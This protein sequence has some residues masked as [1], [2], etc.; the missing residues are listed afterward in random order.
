MD[1]MSLLLL[2][3]LAALG[4]F[5]FDSLHALEVARNAGK[6][7][8]SNAHVQFLDDTVA[9]VSL[10]LVRDQAGRRVLRRTYRF[11][12][13]ETG[14]SRREGHLVLLGSRV[15]SVMMEP[16]RMLE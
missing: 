14:N 7:V 3:L 9:R 11:E 10:A 6:Y 4:W 5:W 8:C 2:L 13:S 12:F 1:V 16:Y 15:E